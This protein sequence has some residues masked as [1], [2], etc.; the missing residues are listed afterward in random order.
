[1]V[2]TPRLR[3][4][5]PPLKL[6]INAILGLESSSSDQKVFGNTKLIQHVEDLGHLPGVIF[7]VFSFAT[8][9]LP[10]ASIF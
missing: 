7:S 6:S 3:P 9:P 2:K 10:A 4:L 8:R 1:M 5:A